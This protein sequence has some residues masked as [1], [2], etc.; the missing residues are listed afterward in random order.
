MGE[1]DWLERWQDNRIGFHQENINSRLIHFWPELRLAAG[2]SVFVPL[3]GK[4]RDMIWLRDQ[5]LHILGSELSELACTDFFNEN[6]IDFS[7]SSLGNLQQFSGEKITL[8]Q[9]DF[10]DISSEM[11][12]T[13]SG[14]FD[15]AALI[16]LPAETRVQYASHLARIL[17]V[18]V[19]I[20]LISME[21][22]QNKMSGPPFSVSEKEIRSLFQTQFDVEVISQSS[23]PDIVGNLKERGLDTLDEKVYLLS[24][25]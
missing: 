22:D 25:S 8:I 11:L 18:S 16:A 17:P 3:C 14:V 10:F 9:G 5:N 4:T 20:L 24:R 12:T 19:K 13:V 6:K 2:S 1:V 15:R 7:T 21:Y 23:G